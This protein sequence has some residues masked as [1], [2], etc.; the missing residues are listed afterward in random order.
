MRKYRHEIIYMSISIYT[1]YTNLSR[2]R[3]CI[4]SGCAAPRAAAPPLQAAAPLVR[5]RRSLC[6]G[7][8]AIFAS[9]LG[10]IVCERRS[11]YR[12][13]ATERRGRQYDRAARCKDATHS[14]GAALPLVMWHKCGAAARRALKPSASAGV[15]RFVTPILITNPRPSA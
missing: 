2:P 14:N 12:Q 11:R 1:R 15:A 13:D 7:R 3:R 4:F 9:I 8:A 10:A 5:L 6:S